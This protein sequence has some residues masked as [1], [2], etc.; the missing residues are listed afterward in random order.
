MLDELLRT[1]KEDGFT[2]KD[3]VADKDSSVNATYCKFFPEGILTFCSLNHCKASLS[4]VI[5]S[6]KVQSSDDILKTFSEGI[7]N[8]INHYCDNDHSSTWCLHDK[9]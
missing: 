9:V 1:A 6:D 3:L 7:V 5:A 2:M 8:I 4:N